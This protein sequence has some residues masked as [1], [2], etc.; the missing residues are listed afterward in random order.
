MDDKLNIVKTVKTKEILVLTANNDKNEN[1]A[2]VQSILDAHPDAQCPTKNYSHLQKIDPCL[3]IDENSPTLYES[4]VQAVETYLPLTNKNSN[5]TCTNTGNNELKTKN[6]INEITRECNL[7]L[8]NRQNFEP[9]PKEFLPFDFNDSFRLPDWVTKNQ[10]P[11]HHEPTFKRKTVKLQE[12]FIAAGTPKLQG[13]TGA[14]TSATDTIQILHKYQ[15]SHEPEVVGVFL[16]NNDSMEP[17]TLKA[18]RKGYIYI[19][20][21]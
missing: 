12:N 15:K 17:T 7:P 3:L 1:N 13:D 5:G 19:S 18:Y 4:Y 2:I 6:I 16:Q 14:N 20:N 9:A 8:T 10:M 11:V 21:I